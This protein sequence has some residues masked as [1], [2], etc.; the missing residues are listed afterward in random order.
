MTFRYNVTNPETG[1]SCCRSD[2]LR[3]LCRRCQ[4]IARRDDARTLTEAA[5]PPALRITERPAPAPWQPAPPPTTRTPTNAR[6]VAYAPD[7]P[8]LTAHLRRTR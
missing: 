7:P 5:P 4:A 3:Y 2:N 1:L 6:P 8:D